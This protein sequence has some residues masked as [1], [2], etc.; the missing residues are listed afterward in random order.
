VVDDGSTDE[1]QSR[2]QEISR[3]EPRLRVVTLDKNQGRAIARTRALEAV[4]GDWIALWDVDDF[5][6]PDRLEAIR[7]AALEAY[8]FWVSLAVQTTLDLRVRGIQAFDRPFP[9]RDFRIGLHGAM[10]FRADLG[11]AIGYA[12]HLKT[13]GGMGE[14]AAIMLETAFRSRGKFDERPL[15]VNVTGN[16]VVLEK[17][18]ASR[19]IVIETL[20]RLWQEGAIGVKAQELEGCIRRLRLRNRVLGWLRACPW[21]YPRI[22]QLRLR[23]ERTFQVTLSPARREFLER[24]ARDLP[25]KGHDSV[26]AALPWQ[27][28]ALL[29][30]ADEPARES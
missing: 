15:M 3:L 14:D 7:V 22:M 2:L 12:P 29:W 11:R 8:D 27:K 16:E 24:V 13:Y 25:A 23:G 1:T 19:Q 20:E 26:L 4:R 21:L 5:F 6:F 9:G 18:L 30:Q 10:A 17:S 28:V